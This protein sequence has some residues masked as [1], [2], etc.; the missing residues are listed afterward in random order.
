MPWRA[1]SVM[2]ER[3]RFVARLLDGGGDDGRVPGVRYFPQDRLQGFR[4]LQGARACGAERSLPSA[5]PLC[6][7][8]AGSDRAPDRPPQ[9]R[10]AALELARSANCWSDSLMAASAF[11]PGAPFTPFSIATAWSSV[12]AC[13]LQIPH[14]SLW[15]LRKIESQLRRETCREKNCETLWASRS[16]RCPP[17]SNYHRC[18]FTIGFKDEKLMGPGSSLCLDQGPT[19]PRS[20]PF[21]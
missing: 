19:R 14:Q 21:S 16:R 10:E 15:P 11:R 9:G 6:Q 2:D 7:P 20:P 12:A 18:E 5:N 13:D 4:S 17:H 8:V 3:L 1:S